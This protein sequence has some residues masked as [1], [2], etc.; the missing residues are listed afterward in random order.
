MRLGLAVLVFGVL[1]SGCSPPE[2]EDVAAIQQADVTCTSPLIVPDISG[3]TFSSANAASSGTTTVDVLGR[4]IDCVANTTIKWE[5]LMDSSP[6]YTTGG[7]V[8]LADVTSTSAKVKIDLVKA[9]SLRIQVCNLFGCSGTSNYGS[10]TVD[11]VLAVTS[12]TYNAYTWSTYG[13][14][15]TNKLCPCCSTQL[16][17]RNGGYGWERSADY[18]YDDF[19]GEHTPDYSNCSDSSCSTMLGLDDQQVGT[20]FIPAVCG[21]Q[22]C[23]V[24]SVTGE[25]STT[26]SAS[27][28]PPKTR[29]GQ[30]G[31]TCPVDGMN[32]GDAC[33][34]RLDHG[35]TCTNNSQCMSGSCTSG[36]CDKQAVG[37]ACRSGSDC[38]SGSCIHTTQLAGHECSGPNYVGDH[39]YCGCTSSSDCN[40]HTCNA[41][42]QCS[43]STTSDCPGL[44]RDPGPVCNTSTSLCT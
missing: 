31:V 5:D 19:D 9:H 43:C 30:P 34:S 16:V 2:A 32:A 36:T 38:S 13:D 22:I 15:S 3:L 23:N 26:L 29:M 28:T 11:P 17:A 18:D 20:G 33:M 42:G 24:S 8:T 44:K 7:A 39:Y 4:N 12:P 1:A 25:S 37:T 27:I 21:A 6:A 40:G 14:I 35:K 41:N 10:F